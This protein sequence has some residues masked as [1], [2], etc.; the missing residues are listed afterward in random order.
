[1]Q[2]SVFQCAPVPAKENSQLLGG[3]QKNKVDRVVALVDDQGHALDDP[4]RI[5]EILVC[6]NRGNNVTPPLQINN[7]QCNAEHVAWTSWPI[8]FGFLSLRVPILWASTRQTLKLDTAVL[9]EAG[10]MEPVQKLHKF[11]EQLRRCRCSFTT[12][13]PSQGVNQ[14][15]KQFLT[16]KNKANFSLDPSLQ[17]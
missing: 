12:N 5:S 10:S 9:E 4:R 15:S 8:C 16:T 1:M 6:Y 2:R 11:K 17:T 13:K 14:I 7:Q 3:R